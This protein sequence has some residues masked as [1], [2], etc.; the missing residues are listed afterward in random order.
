MKYKMINGKKYLVDTMGNL[1]KGADGENVEAPE[2]VTEEHV[3]APDNDDDDATD[4][5]DMKELKALVRKTAGANAKEFIKSLDMGGEFASEMR[6]AY[7]EAIAGK[8]TEQKALDVEAISKGF[9]SAT[10]A[11]GHSYEVEVKTLSELNS[12]TGEVI[13]EDRRPEIDALVKRNIF[14]EEIANVSNTAS[15]KVTWVE[16]LAETGSPATTAELAKFPEKNYTFKVAS[17]EVY[18]VAVMGKASNEILEDGPQLV[19]F[20]QNELLGDLKIKFEDELLSGDGVDK[21][22]GIFNV[23]PAFE[24]GGPFEDFFPAGKSNRLDVLRIAASQITTAGKGKKRYVPNAIF[25]SPTDATTL[26]L[27]KGDDDHYVLAPF[28]NNERTQVKGI[29]IIENP[30]I[31]EGSFLMGDFTKMHI[32]NRRGYSVQVATENVD[33]F[34]KDMISV[35]LSRRAAMYV[36]TNDNGAFV[37]GDFGNAKVDIEATA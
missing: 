12:L 19:A 11:I 5:E 13:E 17:A 26:D 1:I 20:M 14:L 18:K 16:V 6:K 10:K 25:M 32:A 4:D 15:N 9:K 34:E 35:R 37:Y 2:S 33:D 27:I 3:D 22:N 24:T 28:T 29:T 8:T 23:A 30:A 31:P 36:K 7:A 21:F